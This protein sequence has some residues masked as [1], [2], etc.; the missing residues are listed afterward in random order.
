MTRLV[1]LQLMATAL[2]ILRF[3]LVSDQHPGPHDAPDNLLLCLTVQTSL[4]GIIQATIKQEAAPRSGFHQEGWI[5]HP[6]FQQQ[7]S[8]PLQ[9]PFGRLQHSQPKWQGKER[10]EQGGNKDKWTSRNAW[11]AT[12]QLLPWSTQTVSAA[13]TPNRAASQVRLME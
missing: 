12:Q 6:G 1:R 9:Q 8:K 3:F 11:T 13:N 10:W 7:H 5:R 4:S 2:V